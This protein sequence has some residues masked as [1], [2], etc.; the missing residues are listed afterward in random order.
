MFLNPTAPGVVIQLDRPRRLLFTFRAMAEFLG[1]SGKDL[2]LA[3]D[4]DG[5]KVEDMPFLLWAACLHEQP[6]LGLEEVLGWLQPETVPAILRALGAAWEASMPEPRP[7]EEGE[8]PAGDDG[9]APTWLTIWASARHDLGLSE[10]EFWT[11]TP[12]HLDALMVR[13]REWRKAE[14]LRAGL[15]AAT[16]VNVARGLSGGGGDSVMPGDFFGYPRSPGTAQSEEHMLALVEALN[17]AM[18]GQDLRQQP[19]APAQESVP[20]E[21]A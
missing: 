6:A 4:W 2:L 21:T 1:A 19:A 15:V 11:L 18:G 5:V 8:E 17:A 14:N 9:P 16:L 12:R 20:E 3:D 13:H 7:P 10:A